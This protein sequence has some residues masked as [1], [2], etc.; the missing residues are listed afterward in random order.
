MSASN[1]D[2]TPR[3]SRRRAVRQVQAPAQD[4]RSA[5]AGESARRARF[6]AMQRL[7]VLRVGGGPSDATRARAEARW[8]KRVLH[9]S[10]EFGSL[11]VCQLASLRHNE[12]LARTAHRWLFDTFNIVLGDFNATH[13]NMIDVSVD[14]TTH[15]CATMPSYLPGVDMKAP[16]FPPNFDQVV[17]KRPLGVCLAPKQQWRLQRV[18]LF[19]RK[20]MLSRG[21]PSDH[22][23]VEAVVR[24]AASAPRELRVATWNVADPLYYALH[25]EGDRERVLSGFCRES[26]AARRELIVS[27]A[28]QL[29]ER[30][31]V[32]GLQEVPLDLVDRVG[33]ACARSDAA[34]RVQ[35][36]PTPATADAD[37][38][39]APRLVLI[40]KGAVADGRPSG[41][42]HPAGLV[43]AAGVSSGPPGLQPTDVT[44]GTHSLDSRVT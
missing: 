9:T 22:V 33:A 15:A 23:P 25:H 13:L 43:G 17:V 38:L 11:A 19:P 28:R 18:R 29:F 36:L 2:K 6:A 21:I 35:S 4:A 12:T 31:D 3:R 39:R 42:D 32:L 37:G 14:G 20:Q 41:S 1:A 34:A 30:N 7:P 27:T 10:T 40:C 26:E 24:A 16:T 8:I 44:R 5:V